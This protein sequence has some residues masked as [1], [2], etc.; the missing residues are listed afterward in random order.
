LTNSLVVTHTEED[1]EHEVSPDSGLG[2]RTREK[3]TQIRKVVDAAKMSPSLNFAERGDEEDEQ[4][5]PATQKR[6]ST[7]L[8]LTNGTRSSMNAS[9]GQEGSNSKVPAEAD[10]PIQHNNRGELK[11]ARIIRH[12]IDSS[13]LRNTD[14]ILK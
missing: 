6:Y 1:E 8:D 13:L 14:S 4:Y 5:T 12:D 7:Y 9:K 11:S 3:L 2:R 10:T